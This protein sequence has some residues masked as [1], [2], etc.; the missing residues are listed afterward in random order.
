MHTPLPA[1]VTNYEMKNVLRNT[2]AVVAGYAI[3]AVSAVLLF[4]M[5]G[6]NPHDDPSLSLLIFVI[7]YGMVFAFLGG[8]VAQLISPQRKLTINLVLG[9]IM[10]TFATF[11][12]FHSA[13]N[14]FT[15]VAAIFLF[16]PASLLGGLTGLRKIKSKSD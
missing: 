12:L 16:A 9:G 13:G 6:I 1:P 8:L 7:S 2:I 11:S 15:Q 5:S 10:A 4:Q 3:F 14:H